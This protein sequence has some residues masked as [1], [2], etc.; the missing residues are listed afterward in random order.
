MGGAYCS[1]AMD[2]TPLPTLGEPDNLHMLLDIIGG[3]GV[4]IIE[5]VPYLFSKFIRL[6]LMTD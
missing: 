4:Y 1:S 2:W 6:F 5:N 3:G